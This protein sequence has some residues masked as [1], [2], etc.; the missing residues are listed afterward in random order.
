MTSFGED[1][2]AHHESPS[3]PEGCSHNSNWFSYVL[4]CPDIWV[5][6]VSAEVFEIGLNHVI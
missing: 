3:I 2:R 6:Q 4:L 1:M 5:V